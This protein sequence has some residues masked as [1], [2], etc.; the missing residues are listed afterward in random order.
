LFTKK[1][2]IL[3]VLI[4]TIGLIYLLGSSI[5]NLELR[6]GIASYMSGSSGIDIVATGEVIYTIFMQLIIVMMGM[7]FPL[8]ILYILF[9]KQRLVILKRLATI[10]LTV[11]IAY[12]CLNAIRQNANIYEPPEMELAQTGSEAVELPDDIEFKPSGLLV[13]VISLVISLN[14]LG[15]GLL[16]WWLL[17]KRRT[18]MVKI[19]EEARKTL[20]NLEKGG[21]LKE[22]VIKCYHEMSRVLEEQHS[23]KR[24]QAMTT[25]EFE[26]F[27]S[28]AGFENEEIK[29]L[30]R[31]FEKVRYGNKS[32]ELREEQ[33]AV[34]CLTAI[35]QASERSL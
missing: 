7:I 15:G 31:L 14:L 6:R 9:S 25:R 22:G 1:S 24:F 18:P 35:V 17:K 28:D 11:V 26:I 20:N 30:T 2:R 4:G 10:G 33:E 5:N 29:R 21:D 16:V 34:E 23:L 12:F 19:A 8:T 32:L 27:L 13:F 3:L